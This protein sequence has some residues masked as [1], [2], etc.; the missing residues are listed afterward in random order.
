MEEVKILNIDGRELSKKIDLNSIDFVVFSP[1]YW[2]LRDYGYKEQIGYKQDYNAYLEDMKKVFGECFKVLK[3]GRF[4]AINIG[5]VVSNEGMKFIAG[6]FVKKAEEIG[7][8]FRKDILWNKPRGQTKW[9]R[10]AT[11]FSQN[12]YPLKFNTNINHE[13]ILIFQKGESEDIDFS[14]V[15]KFN[16][17]FIREMAY[18]VWD[19]APINS[20]KN[21]EKHVAP[22][23]EELPRRL[24]KLFSFEGDTILDPF[25]GCG[26]TNKVAKELGRNS[27]AVEM[28]KDYCKLIEKKI[29]SV[30]FNSYPKEHYDDNGNHEIDRAKIKLAKAEREYKKALKDYEKLTEEKN[31]KGN[32]KEFI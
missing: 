30:K 15:P 16:R 28:S 29:N 24:I 26:T 23:P 9:Q 8:I 13:Y 19:I 32:L 11:Q 12:P 14:E 22:Y 17:S 25:A 4:M 18:S 21:D 7:F 10:G 1:P 20:P 5:T 31:K 2:K 27:I 6:D 3:N